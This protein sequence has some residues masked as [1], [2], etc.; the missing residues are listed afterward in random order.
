MSVCIGLDAHHRTC[1]YAVK[2]AN[3][4]L[5]EED[6]IPSLGHALLDLADRFPGATVVVEAS[7]VLEWIYD[8]L[9]EHG[10][11]VVPAHPLNV[12]RTLGKG[13]KND[14]LDAGFL[15]DMHRLGVL[16]TA[17]VPPKEIRGLRELVRRRAYLVQQRTRYMNRIH[18]LLKRRGVRIL[19]DDGDGEVE[20]VTDIFAN[21]NRDRLLALNEPEIPVMLRLMDHVTTEMKSATSSVERNAR[22]SEDVQRLLTIPGFGSLTALA[23]FAEIGDVSRFPDADHLAA[24]FGLV[25][26]EDKS[27]DTTK[28]GRITKKGS[29][30]ARWLLGQAAWAHV[31]CCPKSSIAKDYKRLS[32]KKGKKKA[33]VMVARKLAKVSYHLLKERREFTLTG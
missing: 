1:T 16:P 3:G 23:V 28:R 7:S 10:V 21:R 8:T 20:E 13:R 4:E 25:P 5:V 26:T 2:N 27:A 6:T 19:T 24:Y 18:G 15:A 33:I 12:R 14:K 11:K 30:L 32:K 22:E 17:Y 9:T 31:R 29:S